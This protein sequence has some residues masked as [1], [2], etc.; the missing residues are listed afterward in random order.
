MEKVHS[1]KVI[2][3]SQESPGAHPIT[4][5]PRIDLNNL[6][7]QWI[8]QLLLLSRITEPNFPLLS[9]QG[10]RILTCAVLVELELAR[11]GGSYSWEY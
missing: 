2:L 11:E 10:P 5:S 1:R 7:E 8:L 4:Q 6:K 9:N 3:E